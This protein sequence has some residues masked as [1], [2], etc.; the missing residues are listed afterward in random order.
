M[1]QFRLHDPSRAGAISVSGLRDALNALGLR[2]DTAQ[3]AKVVA[4][5][6]RDRSGDIDLYEFKA[7][8]AEVRRF[9]QA[10]VEVVAQPTAVHGDRRQY[11]DS[12]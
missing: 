8:V 9:Q 1:D 5:Y 2:T 11:S 3:A 10:Q 12:V 6:D 4:A 7:L